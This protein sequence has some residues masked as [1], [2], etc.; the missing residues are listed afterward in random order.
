M[1][2][3]GVRTAMV[4]SAFVALSPL[5][6]FFGVTPFVDAP[7]AWFVI[8]A[9]WVLVYAVKWNSWR[10][11]FAAGSLIGC[12]CWLRLNPLYLAIF[13]AAALLVGKW[14]S[15]KS[16]VPIAASLVLGTVLIICPLIIR[17]FMVFGV[18]TVGSGIGANLWEGLGETQYGRSQGFEIGDENLVERGRADLGLPPDA[19][20]TPIWPEGIARDRLRRDEALALIKQHPVWYG[21]V[22]AYRMWGL[23][24]VFGQPVP[25]VGTAGINVT[26]KKT[27]SDQLQGG[28]IALIVD[29]LGMLQSVSRYLLLPL[30]ACGIFPALRRSW[31]AT[32]LIGAAVV[33]YLVPGAAVHTEIRFALPMHWLLPIF[34]GAGT[35]WLMQ[36]IKLILRF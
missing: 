13:L 33:Y 17:N 30:A 8:A 24:K 31:M 3:Y 29:F 11:G 32:S 18:L 20:I 4:A 36:K 7:A 34:A 1:T 21:S 35:I 14:S 9:V 10:I 25:Y 27:L 6:A 15:I 23:L 2:A 28:A 19:P 12:A 16:R 5:I 22:M 26:A